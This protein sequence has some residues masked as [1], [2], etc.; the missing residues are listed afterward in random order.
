MHDRSTAVAADCGQLR[1]EWSP[2]EQLMNHFEAQRPVMC[3]SLTST[4]QDRRWVTAIPEDIAVCY[5]NALRWKDHVDLARTM[6]GR[7]RRE[8]Q[9]R[10]GVGVEGCLSRA[11]L[12]GY[13]STSRR[14]EGTH[15]DKRAT[16]H[17]H[18]HAV[19][20]AAGTFTCAR[21]ND[22]GAVQAPLD[23]ASACLSCPQG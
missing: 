18:A 22:A 1:N 6:R 19:I 15:K 11:D 10:Y 20:H 17:G 9:T 16:Q 14:S 21:P 7:I 23:A 5:T 2:H 13:L 4:E 8:V 3:T 12:D